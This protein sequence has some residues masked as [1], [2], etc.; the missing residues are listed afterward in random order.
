MTNDIILDIPIAIPK[1]KVK[2]KYK[3]NGQVGRVSR[4]AI[5]Q[6]KA[7]EKYINNKK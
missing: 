2:P 5:A 1:L 4:N 3:S 6:M 7:A